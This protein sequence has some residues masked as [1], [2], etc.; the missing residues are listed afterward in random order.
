[1]Q[2]VSVAT[3]T[4]ICY[5]IL[6]INVEKNCAVKIF[7]FAKVLDEIVRWKVLYRISQNI[8]L[9]KS[10]GWNWKV[11]YRISRA[12]EIVADSVPVCVYM[13]VICWM[14]DQSVNVKRIDTLLKTA[15]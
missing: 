1:M 12:A 5:S 3:P 13:N 10:V 15:L 9:C 11:L 6:S 2:S 8:L 7:C 4:I 14:T